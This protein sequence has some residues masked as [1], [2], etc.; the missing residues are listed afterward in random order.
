VRIQYIP[1]RP[2]KQS[3]GQSIVAILIMIEVPFFVF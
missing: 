1:P 2:P 3:L